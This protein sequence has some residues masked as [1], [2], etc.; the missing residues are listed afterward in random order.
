MLKSAAEP[1]E[2]AEF[3]NCLRG[4]DDERYFSHYVLSLDA[5]FMLKNV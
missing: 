3:V 1:R 5:L 4:D 2:P